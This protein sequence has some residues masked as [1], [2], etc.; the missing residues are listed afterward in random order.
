MCASAIKQSRINRI[1]YLLDNKNENI[2]RIVNE[3]L[4]LEDANQPVEKVKLDIN[5]FAPEDVKILSSF[6]KKI[7]N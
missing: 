6:F 2:Q 3:I 5:K 4:F 7:R 1:V